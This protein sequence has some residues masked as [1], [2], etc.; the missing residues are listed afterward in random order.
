MRRS[1]S[2]DLTI[3]AIPGNKQLPNDACAWGQIMLLMLDESPYKLYVAS[4]AQ[5]YA[6]M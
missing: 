5:M 1:G 4:Y 3:G 6:R 2:L